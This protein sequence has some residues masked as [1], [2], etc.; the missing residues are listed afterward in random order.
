MLSIIMCVQHSCYLQLEHLY[1]MRAGYPGKLLC[2]TAMSSK[3]AQGTSQRALK[4]V[5]A[6]ASWRHTYVDN[7]CRMLQL[8]KSD[9]LAYELET[10]HVFHQSTRL[11]SHLPI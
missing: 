2:L 9:K 1:A 3:T 10:T 5:K 8:C 7:R 4:N 6:P 11:V